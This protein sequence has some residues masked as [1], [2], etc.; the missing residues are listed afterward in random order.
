MASNSRFLFDNEF[1]NAAAVEREKEKQPVAPPPV[2]TEEQYQ[3]ALA[4][5]FEEGRLQGE[6]AA[7]AEKEMAANNLLENINEQVQQLNESQSSVHS[8]VKKD[9]AEIAVLCAQK[10]ANS[11]LEQSAEKEV[12]KLVENCLAD[13]IEEPRVVVRASEQ[14]CESLKGRIDAL[15]MSSGFQGQLILLPD[16][17]KTG[18]NCRVEWADGGVEKDI[19]EITEKVSEIVNRYVSSLITPEY[20]GN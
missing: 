1:A 19:A 18:A 9:A 6:Q 8:I 13:M 2:Y 20:N 11:L 17:S 14:V 3:T 4:N 16:D 7:N 10:I 5:A 15:T 12:F